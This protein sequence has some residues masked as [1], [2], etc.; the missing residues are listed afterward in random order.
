[1]RFLLSVALATRSPLS[2]NQRLITEVRHRHTGQRYINRQQP[3]RRHG[4]MLA[5]HCFHTPNMLTAAGDL[6][7]ISDLRLE[8]NFLIEELSAHAP[9]L[10]RHF[11]TNGNEQ[12]GLPLVP[13][14]WTCSVCRC[15]CL[16]HVQFLMSLFPGRTGGRLFLYAIYKFWLHR[17]RLGGN[18]PA[19]FNRNSYYNVQQCRRNNANRNC[20]T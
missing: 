18:H 14:I 11:N 16:G 12:S 20:E 7:Y 10:R 17:I 2:A 6:Q 15:V 8:K 9:R 1:M 4:C 19:Q 5:F 3:T 13:A